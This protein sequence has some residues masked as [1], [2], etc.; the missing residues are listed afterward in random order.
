MDGGSW[1]CTGGS[2]QPFPWK[3][4]TKVKMVIWGGLT[5]SWEKKR[6]EKQGIKGKIYPSECRVSKKIA[7]RDKKAFL[8]EQC[9]E[10]AEN[11][12]MGKAKGS[13]QEK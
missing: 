8:S 13:L 4:Y 3:R 1:H 11:K 12:R 10:I 9:K 2:V 6:T 7:R 5:N